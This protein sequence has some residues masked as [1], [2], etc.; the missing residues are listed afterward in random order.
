M[1]FVKMKLVPPVIS[2][3]VLLAYPFFFPPIFESIIYSASCPV[4]P[5]SAEIRGLIYI[6]VVFLYSRLQQDDLLRQKH[7]G[8]VSDIH[9]W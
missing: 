2:Y 3:P 4:P 1:S 7:R 6:F 5:P 8:Y 9:H